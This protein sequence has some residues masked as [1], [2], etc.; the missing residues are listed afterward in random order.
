M[1]RWGWFEGLF[2]WTFGGEAEEVCGWEGGGLDVCFGREGLVEGGY[3][4]FF[5]GFRD[6]AGCGGCGRGGCMRRRLS[7]NKR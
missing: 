6:L 3:S 4:P 1:V 2:G 5:G 7:F